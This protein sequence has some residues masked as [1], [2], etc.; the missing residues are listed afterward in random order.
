MEALARPRRLGGLACS[1]FGYRALCG[2]LAGILS[3]SPAYG[4]RADEN[5][6]TSADDAFGSQLGKDQT[7]IY[8]WEDVRGFS[9]VK[10]GN[11][12]I[13]GIYFDHLANF[14]RT[15]R[16]MSVR[17]GAAAVDYPFLAPTGI[18]DR[19]LKLPGDAV[20]NTVTVGRAPYGALWM[21]ADAQLPIVQDRLGVGVGGSYEE[22]KFVDG[23]LLKAWT[24]GIVGRYRHHDG[25]VAAFV[26]FGTWDAQPIALT[27]V[28]GPYL[29]KLP[30]PGMYQGQ[31]W[32]EGTTT[33]WNMGV[34]ARQRI[35][36]SISFRGGIFQAIQDK[37]RNFS[38]IVQ[39]DQVD[40]SGSHVAVADPRHL[41][42]AKS[43]EAQ[44]A[45]NGVSGQLRHRVVA[46]VRGRDK[47]SESGGSDVI[48]LGPVML[49]Q[50]D[51]EPR[52]SFKFQSVNVS[53]IQQYSAGISYLG[54]LGR[55]AKLHVGIQKSSYR[56]TFSQ[57]ADQ[58][59]TSDSPWLY[60]ASLALTPVPWLETYVTYVTGLEESG[61]APEN[62]ANRN[63]LLPASRTRQMDGGLRITADGWRVA[64]SLFEI[65]KPYF[66]FD[67]TNQFNSAGTVRH[68]RLELSLTK[69]LD[70]RLNLLFGAVLMDPV[71][72]GEARQTGR[73]GKR[74]VGI[75]KTLVRLDADYQTG[76]KGISLNGS[77]VYTG[78]RAASS[79]TYPA[80]VGKQLFVPGFVNVDLGGRYNFAFQGT[81]M[82]MRLN[83]LNVFDSR[84]WN[85]VASNV[86]LRRDTRRFRV[87]LV[88]D[89]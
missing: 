3:C 87:Q 15:I 73:S 29:P 31:S 69:Q 88:T 82:S 19:S 30:K 10:A 77:V 34:L 45:W 26:D 66:N 85:P 48:D 46:M 36:D 81:Q 68:Q 76:I 24:S 55:L 64:A 14:F 42:R 63:E 52:P 44:L 25:D 84:G 5:A 37:P 12:R 18:I 72:S 60:N 41:A 17:V 35:S 74:P 51:P 23:S 40:G 13:E 79:Q 38:E 8:S 33:A 54:Q 53:H 49:G 39:V 9:A 62:A 86:Y 71:V 21:E 83:V 50:A 4:Q 67:A 2:A 89:F 27:V 6:I 56:A 57:P 58:T 59:R 61:I 43:G 70:S 75:S 78:K 80:L 16:G 28:P 11:V 32:T 47:R 1:M 20:T 7:G 22:T 65:K